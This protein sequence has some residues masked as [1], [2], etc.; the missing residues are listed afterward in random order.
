MD[1]YYMGYLVGAALFWVLLTVPGI[2]LWVAGNRRIHN[3]G[4]Y[5]MKYW[6]IGLVVF[7]GVTFVLGL[8]G[9]AGDTSLASTP[10]RKADSL[11][12]ASPEHPVAAEPKPESKT[13][14][15][16]KVAVDI[17]EKGKP[18][19]IDKFCSGYDM[20][21]DHDTALAV[22]AKSYGT[23]TNP[24]AEEVFDEMLSRCTV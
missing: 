21:G 20:I 22:F 1:A 13:N 8:A 16:A 10:E 12:Q 18:G 7:F 19:I 9:L 15:R 14:N 23:S 5:T 3:G 4:H 6:G 17:I 11:A 2:W 24:S